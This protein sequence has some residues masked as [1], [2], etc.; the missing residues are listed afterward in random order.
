MAAAVV[1]GPRGPLYGATALVAF[2]ALAVVT[3]LSVT[4]AIVPELAYVEAGRTLAY[5][6]VFAGA[7]AGARLAPRAGPL[8]IKGIL[9]AAMAA[10]AYA[11]AS[12]VWPGALAETEL[13]NRIGQPFQYWNAVGTTAALAVPGLLWLGSR[14]EASPWVR[15]LAYP[16]HGRRRA[17][18]PADAVARRARRRGAGRDHLARHRAAAAAIAARAGSAGGGC[19]RPGRLGAFEGRLRR[20]RAGLAVKESVATEFG[21]LLVLMAALLYGAGVA[22]NVGLGRWSRPAEL[23]RR[24]GIAALSGAALLVVIALAALSLSDRGLTG[25]IADRVDELTSETETAPTGHRRRALHRRLV[26]ARQVLARG[27]PGVR[28]PPLGGHR[29]R[30]L[31]G[32]PAAPPHRHERHRSRPR[33]RAADARRPRPRGPR[34]EPAAAGRLAAGGGAQHGDLPA[35]GASGRPTASHSWRSR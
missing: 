11:L 1:W 34:R 20:H 12:R 23:R 13:S 3:A 32:G 33:L 17:R 19:G 7:V 10:I 18:D 2:L 16:G 28:G 35:P 25:T 22:V 8:A 15:A 30:H 6:A 26:H 24:A 5:L 29:R 4:W 31:P 21:L 9:L 14:R 27:A